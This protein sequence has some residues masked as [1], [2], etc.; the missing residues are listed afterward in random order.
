[1]RGVREG[2]GGRGG[3]ESKQGLSR[4]AFVRTSLSSFFART[5]AMP[6]LAS[7]NS[8]AGFAAARK[9]AHSSANLP[10]FLSRGKWPIYR[11]E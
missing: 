10:D 5:W 11:K 9:A 3:E 2:K 6:R 7:T 1:M 8:G 4:G